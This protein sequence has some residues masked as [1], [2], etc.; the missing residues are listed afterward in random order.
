[1]Q[2]S[3]GP[4]Y[5]AITHFS[6]F[7]IITSSKVVQIDDKDTSVLLHQVNLFTLLSL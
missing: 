3:K 5:S 4:E 2:S 6:L 1:M 7:P